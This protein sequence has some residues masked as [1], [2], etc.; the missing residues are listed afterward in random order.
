MFLAQHTSSGWGTY[1]VFILETVGIL[2]LIAVAGWAVVRF[3]SSRLPFSPQNRRLKLLERLVLEPRRALH[4]VQLDDT[5]LLIGTSDQSVD[6]L[7][8]LDTPPA[9]PLPPTTAP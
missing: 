1:G 9:D 5:V 8:V 3:G 7:K 6:L 2:L 4:L